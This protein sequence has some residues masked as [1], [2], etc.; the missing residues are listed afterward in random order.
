[1]KII[2]RYILNEIKMPVLFGISLFTFVFLIDIIVKLMEIIIKGISI[3]DVIR[4]LSFSLP[5]ILPQTIPMGIFLGVM[6]TFAK[7]TKTSETTAMSTIGL[8]IKDI[9][10][11]IFYL[12]CVVTVFI[13]FLQESIIPRSMNK[14]KILT[15]KTVPFQLKDRVFINYIPEY[16]IYVNDLEDNGNIAK[17]VLILQKKSKNDFPRIIV[18]K[19]AYWENM[20]I[21]IEDSDFYSFDNKGAKSL[22]GTF[23]QKKIPL[24]A[25]LAK[26]E[27]KIKDIEM[28]GVSDLLKAMKTKNKKEKIIYEIEFHKKLALPLSTIML[29]LLGVFLSIGHHR[30]GKGVNFTISLIIIFSYITLLNVAMAIVKKG[31][32]PVVIGIWTPNLILLFLTIFMYKQKVK[33]I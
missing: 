16:G 30:S 18:G 1:M 5:S 17:G 8:S 33:V 14:L 10:R 4:I 7:L 9:I 28:L 11:P 29:S 13:F 12:S 21:V 15:T 2:D 6:F 26:T 19:K 3:I 22:T 32:V 24:S 31:T 25:Y 20:E 23:K 27:Y